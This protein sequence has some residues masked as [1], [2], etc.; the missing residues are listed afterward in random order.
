MLH[1]SFG[2]HRPEVTLASD[3]GYVYVGGC[4]PLLLVRG[5]DGSSLQA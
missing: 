5:I 3:F 1:S 2:V 4:G